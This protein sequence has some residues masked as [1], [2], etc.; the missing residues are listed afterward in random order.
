MTAQAGSKAV[1][2][3]PLRVLLWASL[4]GPH[5]FLSSLRGLLAVPVRISL[6]PV[7][8]KPALPFC[9]HAAGMP[10]SVFFPLHW[11]WHGRLVQYMQARFV[12][13]ARRGGAFLF[14]SGQ[15][16]RITIF[17]CDDRCTFSCV[18]EDP[19]PA[20]QTRGSAMPAR[21]T[22]FR[23]WRGGYRGGRAIFTQKGPSSPPSPSLPRM[24]RAG[25]SSYAA[26]A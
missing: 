17:P 6:Q 20:V 8:Q 16:V 2:P 23:G 21:A 11:P 3:F 4:R 7:L 25:Q 14:C 18:R 15:E 12:R 10:L 19:C 1:W 5:F 13:P 24:D 26:L 9:L 22:F